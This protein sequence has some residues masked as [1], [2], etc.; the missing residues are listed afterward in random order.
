MPIGETTGTLSD[1]TM[2]QTNFDSSNPAGTDV[3]IGLVV[4]DQRTGE[5]RKVIYVDSRIVL[6]RDETGNTTLV[7]RDS[8]GSELGTRY[9]VRRDADP[10][11]DA[12]QYDALRGRLAEYESQPGR[13]AEHKADALIE[14]LDLLAG[15][16]DPGTDPDGDAPRGDDPGADDEEP[17]VPFEDVPGIGP[18]TARNLRMRGFATA[19]DVR[20]AGD[21]EILAVPGVGPK[22][23]ANIRTFVE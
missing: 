4:E 15:P 23:L 7:T 17:E 10:S 5:P 21:E 18:E 22:N 20:A 16:A 11:I 6:L 13:K 19:D 2:A 8:F 3:L 9:R 12:G 14:A 1:P